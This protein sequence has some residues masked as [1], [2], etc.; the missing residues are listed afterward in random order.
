[1]SV[2][3]II[4]CLDIADGRV[5]K[6]INFV[7]LKDLDDPVEAAIRYDEQGADALTMLDI[8]ATTEGRELIFPLVKKV[9]A[10]INIPLIVGGG[11]R[12]VDDVRKLLDAGASQASFGSAAV[13][14]PEVVSE[15]AKAFGSASVVVAIDAKAR[16]DRSIQE[17]GKGWDVFTQAGK[18]NTKLDVV[19]WAK[20]VEELGAGEIL[21][22]SMDRDGDKSGFDLDLIAAVSDAVAIPVIASGGVGTL[23]HLADGILLGRADAVLAASIFHYGDYTV[24]QAKEFLAQQGIEVRL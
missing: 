5:V 6:G 3:R 15:A 10:K 11:V 1:M 4:P 16:E 19:E 8:T 23:Q 20:R 12:Q 7:D 21:L 17:R 22:T 13:K 9:A 2:K 24:R 14:T 18:R